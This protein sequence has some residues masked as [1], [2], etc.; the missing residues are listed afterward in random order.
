M[1]K[2]LLVLGVF[3]GVLPVKA[4]TVPIRV[5]SYNLLNFPD[6]RNDCGT[7][8]VQV[9]NRTDSLRK[10][11]NYLKPDIFV[12]CEIQYEA[13]CDSILTRSLNVFGESAYQRAPF[14]GNTSGAN[15]LH[16]MLFY[17]TQKLIL[18]EQRIIPTSV[19]D[20]NQYILY[21]ID[22]T[23]PQHHDTCF[24]EVFMC[25]LK[26]GSATADQN[27][28]AQQTQI[29]RGI[30]D[31]RPADRHLF[32]C[33]DMNTYRSSE[34]C[35]QNL[36][37]GGTSYLKDPVN[38][39]G[40][41]NSN[42][43]FAAIHTQSPRSNG[44]FDC[45]ST[46]GL[47]DR[48]DHILVSQNVMSGSLL[49][50]YQTNSYK[51]VGNDGNHYNQSLLSGSNS[52]FPDSVVRALYYTSDHLPVKLD[53]LVTLPTSDGLNLTYAV[54]GVNCGTGGANI[55][56]TPNLGQAPYTYLWDA[57]A[58][59]QTT[60]SVSGLSAGSYCV[61]VTDANGLTDQLCLEVPNYPAITVSAFPSSETNGCDGGAFLVVTGGQQPYTVTWNDPAQTTG[62]TISNL[63]AGT[64]VCTV[65]DANNCTITDTVVIYGVNGLDELSSEN[66]TLYPNPVTDELTIRVIGS[67]W[68]QLSVDILATDGKWI[69]SEVLNAE[70][71]SF[72]LRMNIPSGVYFLRAGNRVF[73]FVKQ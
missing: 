27:E 13:A 70:A 21:V 19:R 18:K 1:F 51:S 64:Y 50:Q 25:H 17:N 48:F 58:G 38:S 31:G 20:I 36:T 33:G 6:G 35:Y 43:S 3:L 55:T 59:S 16:N 15:D 34:P 45:G 60:A 53:A 26:A 10:T 47:D 14:T 40:N 29:L 62:T 49:L 72:H 9:P 56:V 30:L 11:L 61:Q 68:T 28:R 41:W 67:S 44:L 57:N 69:Q 65:T 5:V 32:V 63:C 8:N 46:G 52:Q 12:A 4:Q 22:P 73:R 54:D 42:A 71:G 23:L 66:I 7:S 2:Y 24:I 37:T 39:P